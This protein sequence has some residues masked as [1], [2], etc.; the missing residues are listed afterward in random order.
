[1]D[2]LTIIAMAGACIGTGMLVCIL[3]ELLSDWNHRGRR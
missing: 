3:Y 2:T 1:M